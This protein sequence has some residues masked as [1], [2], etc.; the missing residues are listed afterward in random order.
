[1]NFASYPFICFL[2]IV[3]S[4]FLASPAK[5][6]FAILLTASYVFY[7]FWSI[8][9][10]ALLLATTT[11]DYIASL[12]INRSQNARAR[13]IALGSA[14]TSNLFVLGGFKYFNFVGENVNFLTTRFHLNA[15][16]VPHSDIILPLGIS[17]FTFEAISYVID[18]YRGKKMAKN[19][20]EYN[21]YI[22]YF[23]HLVAGPIVRFDELRKQYACP[24]Q[25]PSAERLAKGL[26][27]IVLGYLFKVVI[28]DPMGT[29]SR[30]VFNNPANASP[31]S[32]LTS[33]AQFACCLYFDFLGYTHIARGVSLLFNIELP[34]N[35]NHPLVAT[36]IANFWQRWQISL[37]KWLHDYLYIPLGGNTKKLSK[38]MG[39]AFLT[40]LVA[41]I[42]HG[43][44]WNFVALGAFYGTLVAAYHG[45][46]AIR[47]QI[48]GAY[49]KQVVNSIPYR[50]TSVAFTF[51]LIL[52]SSVFFHEARLDF[53]MQIIGK[54][55]RVQAMWQEIC[56]AW[57]GAE[58]ILLLAPIIACALLL[59]GPLF[60]KLYTYSI[61]KFPYWMKLSVA[62]MSVMLCWIVA[63]EASKTFI[64]FQF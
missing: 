7:A 3:S 13:R 56:Q 6:R 17:Y 5:F 54:T 29:V 39:I 30:D 9:F 42:W 22:M 31:L 41:G 10:L 52:V 55:L 51:Y 11:L 38:R 47:A 26:E 20:L 21:F 43:A 44:G 40:L 8:P 15:P 53:A 12:F 2:L 18:V 50:M 34:V 61:D 37:S 36:N 58:Y 1:M 14:I 45:Y 28:A 23:P 24:I 33:V 25:F 57:K 60:E 63:T 19:W 62:T 59:T 16:I 27:L 64:Y 48:F 46:R 35:F 32:C 49:E 4:S